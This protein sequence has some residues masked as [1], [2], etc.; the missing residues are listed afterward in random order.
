MVKITI[1]RGLILS[2][3]KFSHF[4]VGFFRLS[5]CNSKWIKS[6]LRVYLMIKTFDNN[7]TLFKS[8]FKLNYFFF[9][10]KNLTFK[11]LIQFFEIIQIFLILLIFFW[12]LSKLNLLHIYL[13]LY[14]LKLFFTLFSF[15]FSSSIFLIKNSE[16]LIGSRSLICLK[17]NLMN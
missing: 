9:M 10:I 16:S 8:L 15:V 6:L 17:F 2:L 4:L 12:K 5:L 11:L 14:Y 1:W 7:L 13:F 3:R